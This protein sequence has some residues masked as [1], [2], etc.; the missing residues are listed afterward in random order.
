MS[1]LSQNSRYQAM[2]LKEGVYV[3]DMG[4]DYPTD[5]P[6]ARLY[7]PVYDREVVVDE[8]YPFVDDSFKARCI[9]AMGWFW[10]LRVGLGIVLRVKMGLRFKGRENLKKYK[11]QLADGAIT[12]GNHCFRLDCPCVLL[13]CGTK[14]TIKIPMFAPNFST[15]DNFFLRAVGG[16]PIPDSDKG[17]AAIKKFN[18]AF[19][20]YHRRGY[21][22]HVFPEAARWD[23]YKPLR[24]FQKGAFTMAYKYDMPLLPCV[25]TYRERKGIYRLFGPKN[26]PLLQVEIGEPIF[27]DKTQPRGQEVERLR[28]LAHERMEQMAGIEHNPWPVSSGN[29]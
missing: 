11:D 26:L 10:I 1:D 12:L 20:E 14:H 4:M 18:E 16:V 27:P 13:A 9:R 7:R 22:F 23:F 29:L 17:I 6:Y 15:K 21:W 19:D 3:P 2:R 28:T 24:P 25:I 5:D 8:H